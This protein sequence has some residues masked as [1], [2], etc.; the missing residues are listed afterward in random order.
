MNP[1]ILTIRYLSIQRLYGISVPIRIFLLL[2]S[3]FRSLQ[4]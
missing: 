2:Q 3:K 1:I 4:L